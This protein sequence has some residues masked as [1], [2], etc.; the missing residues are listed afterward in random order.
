MTGK[1]AL[2]LTSAAMAFTL[3]IATVLTAPPAL[4]YPP[5]VGIL[6]TS[7]DCLACHVNNGPWK[8][9][10]TLVLDVLDKATGKS[11]R[12]KDGTFAIAVKRGEAV[13]VLT[14]LGTAKGADVAVPYRNAWLY[15][16]PERIK[17]ETLLSKFAPGW[18][19]NLPMS[20]RLVGDV[21]DAYAD[22]KVTVLPMTLRP[23]DDAKDAELELQ[24][25][26]TKGESVKGKPKEGLV[27]SYF[28]RKVKLQ[29]TK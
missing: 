11:L 25:M 5:A 4:A 15:V 7:R 16:D 23:G 12:Q 20:C 18:A 14:V 24:I 27:G 21:L 2:L 17:D 13:T 3:C 9:D 28:V 6:G 19:V 10:A 26:L 1:R 8:D 22:A 29:V